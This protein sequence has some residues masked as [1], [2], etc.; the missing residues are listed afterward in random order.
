[1]FWRSTPRQLDLRSAGLQAAVGLDGPEG[2]AHTTTPRG[3]T[4]GTCG[5]TARVDMVDMTERRAYLTCPRCART[6]DTDRD[7]VPRR[8]FVRLR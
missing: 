7:A 8:P 2:H 1:M 5:G 4:C 6:W 3:L